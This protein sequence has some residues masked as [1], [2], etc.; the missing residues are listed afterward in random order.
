MELLE[1]LPDDTTIYKKARIHP[2]TK[3]SYNWRVGISYIRK[4]TPTQGRHR[5]FF[6]VDLI[7]G[8]KEALKFHE[9]AEK[10]FGDD[11]HYSTKKGNK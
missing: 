7:D 11:Y 8:L 5:D 6:A 4:K 10:L 9:K 1:L 2:D 3:K